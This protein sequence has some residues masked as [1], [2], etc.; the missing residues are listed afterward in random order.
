V[1][2]ASPPPALADPVLYLGVLVGLVLGY[3]LG[4][5]AALWRRARTA[6]LATKAGLPGMRRTMWDQWWTLVGRWSLALV[7]VGVV[8]L[9]VSDR[10]AAPVGS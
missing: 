5:A 2:L 9:A 6:Y 7:V 10:V 4:Y 8:V 1:L 3:G